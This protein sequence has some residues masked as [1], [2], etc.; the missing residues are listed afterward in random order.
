MSFAHFALQASPQALASSEIAGT[1]SATPCSIA[2]PAGTA[3]YWPRN[4]R[5]RRISFVSSARNGCPS[6]STPGSLSSAITTGSISVT[7]ATTNIPPPCMETWCHNTT[8]A[9]LGSR[10]ERTSPVAC[11]PTPNAAFFAAH[12][13]A[14]AIAISDDTDLAMAPIAIAAINS[15]KM[16]FFILTPPFPDRRSLEKCRLPHKVSMNY[17]RFGRKREC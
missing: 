15:S 9:F 14:A 6:S 4:C 7:G 5:R 2:P 13:F 3:E 12:A 8:P 10:S 1:A 11:A 17:T 16:L